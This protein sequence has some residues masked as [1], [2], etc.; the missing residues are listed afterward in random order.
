MTDFRYSHHIPPMFYTIKRKNYIIILWFCYIII[1]TFF[2]NIPKS[3]RGSAKK[4][5]EG[6]GLDHPDLDGSIVDSVAVHDDSVTSHDSDIVTDY[7]LG[8]NRP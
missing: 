3:S 8:V 4:G 1:V 6:H 5:F 7:C 2:F